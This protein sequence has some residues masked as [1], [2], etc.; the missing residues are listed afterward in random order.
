MALF[1]DGGAFGFCFLVCTS[2]I[3]ISLSFEFYLVGPFQHSSSFCCLHLSAFHLNLEVVK[4]ILLQLLLPPPF[5]HS[6]RNSSLYEAHHLF[7][8]LFLSEK[9]NKYHQSFQI[10]LPL[11]LLVNRLQLLILCYLK[12]TSNES[13]IFLQL[14]RS[15]VGTSL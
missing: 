15:S 11:I 1:L 7:I 9:Y 2:S 6:Q 14:V 13:I 4:M 12:L 8:Q 10:N 3:L 5:S